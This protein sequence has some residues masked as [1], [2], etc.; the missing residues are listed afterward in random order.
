MRN[1]VK[2]TNPHPKQ[3]LIAVG[4]DGFNTMTHFC[5]RF[6][7][8]G[9]R[10]NA[11]FGDTFNTNQPRNS[12]RQYAGFTTPRARQHQIIAQRRTHRFPL[13]IV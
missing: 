3:T 4:Q 12:V 13:F 5:R 2:G 9:H 8:K 1:T 11:S 6:V 7:G 10:H